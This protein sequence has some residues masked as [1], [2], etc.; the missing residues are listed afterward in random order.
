[1]SVKYER[2][3][4]L[5][6]ELF[7]LDQPELDFGLYRVMH[8]RSAEV[9]QFLDQDLLPQI[10]EEFDQ[11]KTADTADLQ[12]E[13]S[14]VIVGIEAAGMNPDDSP[15]VT[16]LR[17]RIRSNTAGSEALEEDVYDHLFGFFRRYYS[18]G[19]FVAKRVY[20]PGVYAI[21][22]EG[23]EVTIHWANK[24][25]HYVKTSEYL[26]DYTFCLKPGV[27][28]NPMRVHFRLVDAAQGEHGNVRA[29]TGKDR[30]FILASAGDSGYDFIVDEKGNQGKELVV[31]FEYRSATLADWS[32]S[33]EGHSAGRT[34][35][36]QRELNVITANSILSVEAPELTR[37]IT[38]LRRIDPTEKEPDRTVLAKHLKKYCSVNEFDYFVH[39]DLGAFLRLEL[40]FYIKNE[41]LHLDDVESES[42]RRVE[43]YLEGVDIIN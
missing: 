40:D 16:D 3:K 26:R 5:L 35:P 19:D 7:Q 6:K 24:N 8:A 25:Q 18:D 34:S 32:K 4:T 43:Q 17:N 23:E 31:C 2:L 41:V 39:K 15:T 14:R 36:S 11:Y 42:P 27:S 38:E 22:Y 10:K 29:V 20:K 33:K 12:Q 13:L 37:W 28:S 21:P 1:M 30:K 9:S